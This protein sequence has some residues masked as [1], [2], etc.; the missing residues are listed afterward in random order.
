MY[1]VIV[2]GAGPAG[3]MAS[4]TA[5][6]N[7]RNVLL[8][9]KNDV[10]GKKLS[11]TGGGRCNITNMKSTNDFIK[12]LS[13]NNKM[14]YSALTNFGPKEII[15]YFNNLGV[16]FKIE[17]DNKVFPSSNKSSTIIDALKNE[18]INKKVN[19][20]LN[21]MVEE[22]KINNDIKSV[23][24]NKDEYQS[25]NIIIATGGLSYSNTGSSGD[26][27]VFAKTINQK[28]TDLY[29]VETF[30]ITKDKYPLEGITLD[31]VGISFENKKIV[32]PLLFTHVGLSGPTIFKLSEHIYN[33]LIKENDVSI[34]IDFIP[35]IN[36][37]DLRDIIIKGDQNRE[38]VGLLKEYLPRRLA[39]FL[40]I[41]N[42]KIN[43]LTKIERIELINKVKKY[44]I[45]IIST[46][47]IEQSFITGGGIDMNYINSKTMESTIN[48]GIYFIGELLDIHGPI[49]GYN[50][51]LALS[52][53]YTAGNS[54]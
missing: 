14:L 28:T 43:T 32:G 11:I 36:E 20:R 10:I 48:K 23:K 51:T 41:N 37:N 42:K 22:I 33:R 38:V 16:N 24:T 49:G 40:I 6:S 54:I 13:T 50:I 17:E 30:V 5:A 26:G 52:T 15:E 18:L 21:E 27:Y 44:Q 31:E 53:G 1:D 47:T 4:I 9:E 34:F 2:I 46:G 12:D 39:E 19:I 7:G 29:P 8:I 3:L 45:D 35:N 25:K